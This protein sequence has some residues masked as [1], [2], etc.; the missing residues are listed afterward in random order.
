V[1]SWRDLAS[2][3][4]Q[5]DLDGLLDVVLRLATEQ[6]GKQGGFVPFAAGV[7]DRGEV[8]LV[9][10]EEDLEDGDGERIANGVRDDVRSRRDGFRAVAVAVD[11]RLPE[12]GRDGVRVELEHRD[13]V[14]L[15]VVLP[16]SQAAGAVEFGDLSASAGTAT[17]W[18]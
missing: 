10:S 8:E 16:Y 13:G 2:T 12:Q 1:S 4:A 3:S 15:S 14:A 5:S 17:I 7:D 11:V 9:M 6:I 18:T